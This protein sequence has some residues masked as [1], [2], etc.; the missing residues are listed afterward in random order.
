VVI[1]ALL[2]SGK[3]LGVISPYSYQ[4]NKIRFYLSAAK[5][6]HVEINTIDRYQGNCRVMFER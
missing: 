3:E 4:L 2:L 6:E 5:F 1:V